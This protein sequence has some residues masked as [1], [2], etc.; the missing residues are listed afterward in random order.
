MRITI[1]GRRSEDGQ[2][3]EEALDLQPIE[4]RNGP[5]PGMMVTFDTSDGLH[6]FYILRDRWRDFVDAGNLILGERA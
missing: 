2:D 4:R 6:S 1:E 5:D 3:I